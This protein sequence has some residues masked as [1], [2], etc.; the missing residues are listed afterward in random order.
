MEQIYQLA[1]RENETTA[2]EIKFVVDEQSMS[3]EFQ[4]PIFVSLFI[5]KIFSCRDFTLI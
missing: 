1:Q 2:R 4:R 5:N 3:I